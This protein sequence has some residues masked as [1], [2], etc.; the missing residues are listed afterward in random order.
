MKARF[1]VTVLFIFALL[2]DFIRLVLPSD[3]QYLR[4]SFVPHISFCALLCIVWKRNAMDRLL[5]GLLFGILY[6]AFFMGGVT[7]HIFIY[8][9]F[10][11]VSGILQLWMD[12]DGKFQFIVL[13]I[14]ILLFDLIPFFWNRFTGNL[15]VSIETWLIYMEA[16]TAFLHV[17]IVAFMIYFFDVYDRY[18]TIQKIRRQRQEKYKYRN[19]RLTRK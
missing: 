15:H 1:Y 13:W 3:F 7:I 12:E 19:L 8:P 11:F 16:L 9:L 6:D 4:V 17:G 2:D 14:L 18:A 5:M 10:C